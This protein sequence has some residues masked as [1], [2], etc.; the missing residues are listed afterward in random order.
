MILAKT[1]EWVVSE[2][3]SENHYI[4]MLISYGQGIER[5]SWKGLIRGWKRTV[6]NLWECWKNPRKVCYFQAINFGRTLVV[7]FRILPL[8][9]GD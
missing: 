4:L 7:L 5:I 3:L 1:R 2:V 8:V 9:L 6:V